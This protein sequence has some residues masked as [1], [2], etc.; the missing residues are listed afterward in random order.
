MIQILRP[1]NALKIH[2]FGENT[3]LNTC[4]IPKHMLN[5]KVC[6]TLG[7]FVTRYLFQKAIYIFSSFLRELRVFVIL[8]YAAT[9]SRFSK[10]IVH[11]ISMNGIYLSQFFI[12][13]SIWN[14]LIPPIP[15]FPFSNTTLNSRQCW[16]H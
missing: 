8:V 7:F 11:Q 13:E 1:Q 12:S 2:K 10:H 5:V 9:L 4:Y 14:T 3:P 16:P 15:S 6:K